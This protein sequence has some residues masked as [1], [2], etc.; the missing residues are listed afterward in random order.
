MVVSAREQLAK[1]GI[2]SIRP[3]P[4]HVGVMKRCGRLCAMVFGK[5]GHQYRLPSASEWEYAARAGGETVYPWASNGSNACASAT[6]AD[7]SAARRYPGWAA[8]ACD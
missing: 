7:A 3:A 5:T 6:V 4:G 8:F 2:R 1:S